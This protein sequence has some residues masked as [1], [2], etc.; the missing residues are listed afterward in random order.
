MKLISIIIFVFAFQELFSQENIKKDYEA[1]LKEVIKKYPNTDFSAVIQEPFIVISDCPKE[2]LEKKWAIGTIKW[3]VTNLK[4]SY[5]TKDPDEILEIWL[6]KNKE[7]YEKN[8]KILWGKVPSTPYGYYSPA[9]KVLVMNIATGGGTLVHEIVHPYI[10]ANFPECPPWFN[11]GLGSLYEQSSF[12]NNKIWG[13]TNWRLEGL[14]NKIEKGKLPT[15]EALMKFSDNE[16]Y[17]S[18]NGSYSD[19]YA[20]SRYLLYYLQENDLLI[21]YYK[22]FTANKKEDPTG[23]QTLKKLL[24]ESDMLAFQKKWET[25]VMTLEFP[26]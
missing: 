14:K 7:S 11:E 16:F 6:F 17:N 4:K 12:K 1:H 19:N 2:H 18:E 25:Y 8:A 24:K 3:A 5:F 23:Y 13:L 22:E 10:H 15:F 21:T 26:E 20:Q 9:D